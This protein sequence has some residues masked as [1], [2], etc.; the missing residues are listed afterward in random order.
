MIKHL[1]RVCCLMTSLIVASFVFIVSTA[2]AEA[3]EVNITA[4]VSEHLTVKEI[5][6]SG[7]VSYQISTNNAKG[8][9]VL[10]DDYV[11]MFDGP[12]EET[13]ENMSKQIVVMSMY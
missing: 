5:S 9:M 1:K 13:I 10:S 4:T 3:P 6:E 11:K 8:F 7:L 2:N 12:T